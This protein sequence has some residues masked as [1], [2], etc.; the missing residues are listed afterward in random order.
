MCQI[1]F[2]T[3]WLENV[4]EVLYLMDPATELMTVMSY[5]RLV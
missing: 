2:V 3:G 1:V 4:F 5:A